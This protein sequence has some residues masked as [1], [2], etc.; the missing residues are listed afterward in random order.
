MSWPINL[1]PTLSP[2]RGENVFAEYR[3][4]YVS[5]FVSAMRYPLSFVSIILSHK[6]SV[7]LLYVNTIAFSRSSFLQEKRNWVLLSYP[8]YGHWPNEKRRDNFVGW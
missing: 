4:S 5:I 3:T 2:I 1:L 7:R 6:I 8:L